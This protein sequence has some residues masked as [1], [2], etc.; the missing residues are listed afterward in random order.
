MTVLYFMLLLAG[1]ILFALAAMRVNSPKIDLLALGLALVFAVPLIQ[2]LH[3][4]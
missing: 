1:V 4:L 3:N 2:T